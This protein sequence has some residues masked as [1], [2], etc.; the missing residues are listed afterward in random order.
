[1]QGLEKS[2]EQALAEIRQRLSDLAR[3]THG[4]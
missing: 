3:E 4:H 2:N 1:M